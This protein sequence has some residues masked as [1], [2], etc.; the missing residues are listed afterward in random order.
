MKRIILLCILFTALTTSIGCMLEARNVTANAEPASTP[1]TNA[2]T[3]KKTKIQVAIL[4]DT[5]GSMQ[6]LI[7][8]AKSRLWNIVNTLTTLKYKGETPEIEIALYEY[9]S[10]MLYKVIISVK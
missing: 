6:G 5:S 10:Y 7:E 4:L 3:A 9:G 2:V 1:V 8:Q